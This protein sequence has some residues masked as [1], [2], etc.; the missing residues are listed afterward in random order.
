MLNLSTWTYCWILVK[1][2]EGWG[3]KLYNLPWPIT[4]KQLYLI[5][6]YF[7][8][9]WCFKLCKH[10]KEVKVNIWASKK[11]FIQ[12]FFSLEF[13]FCRKK[14]YEVSCV[15][16]TS[17]SSQFPN[18]Y[19]KIGGSSLYIYMSKLFIF[20]WR[21]YQQSLLLWLWYLKCNISNIYIILYKY[22][23]LEINN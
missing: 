15:W 7:P 19:L 20:I 16:N 22:V 23:K 4:P 11:F 18:I 17:H 13:N 5:C 12:L 3:E 1:N 21:N 10:H 14:N 8:K 9:Y 6:S 2:T